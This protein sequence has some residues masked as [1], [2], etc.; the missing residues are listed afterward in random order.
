MSFSSDP[1]T[2]FGAAIQGAGLGQPVIVADGL[3]HRFRAEGDKPGSRSGWYVLH[4]NGLPAG[5]FGGWRLGHADTW[6]AKDRDRLTPRESRDIQRI[7]QD[8]IHQRDDEQATRN[9]DAAETARRR[10]EAASPADPSHPYLIAKQIQPHG[11]RRQG[12]L[13]LMPI[14]IEGELTSVQTIA[15][16]GTKRF[17][18][19]GRI[20]GGSYVI[21]DATQRPEL[22][23]CEGFATGA[24]LHEQIGATVYVAFN[25]GNLMAVA[26]TVRRQH[27]QAAIV[28]AGDDDRWTDGNPGATKA[29]AAARAV[30]AKLLLPD[31]TGMDLATRPTDWNDWHRLTSARKEAQ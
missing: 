25:A 11:L 15:P 24:T 4:V 12:A 21:N 31:F 8:A 7:I 19:G 3:L 27:P 6:C 23:V 16:D 22:V 1:I 18:R 10:W 13:I 20:A 5:A 2:D 9:R 14:Y 29:R 17:L 28:I 26:R 30:N